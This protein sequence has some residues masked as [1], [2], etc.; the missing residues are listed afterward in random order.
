VTPYDAAVEALLAFAAALLAL[1]FAGDLLRRYRARR[2]PELAAWAA[3][4]LAYA[5]ASGALAWGAAAGWGEA[6]FRVYYLFGGLLTAPL[7]GLGSLLFAG[8]RWALPVALVYAGLAF[9]VALAEP[10]AR[11]VGGSTIPEAQAHLDVFPARLLAIA[12]NS[13]GTLAVVGVAVWTVRRRPLGNALIVAGVAVAAVG[14]TLFGTGV[15]SAG[16]SIGVAALLLYG[17][18]VAPGGRRSRL[19]ARVAPDDDRAEH[20]HQQRREREENVASVGQ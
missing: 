4:L 9:G 12:G 14:S 7:L 10:L 1:R 3:S 16:A 2:A 11:P 13:A 5:L 20:E 8:R 6:A 15:A 18:F 19:T 17:G